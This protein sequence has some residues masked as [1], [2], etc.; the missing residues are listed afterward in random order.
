[1]SLEPTAE[2]LVARL[3]RGDSTAAST[4]YYRYVNRL[5]ALASSRL[6]ER[7]RRM[8]DP[9]EVALSACRSF[10]RHVANDE[11]PRN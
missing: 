1:M 2:Q 9:E 3:R 8:V 10:F 7:M 4:I 5:I 6:D 11:S